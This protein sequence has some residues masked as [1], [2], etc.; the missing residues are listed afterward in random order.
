MLW[1]IRA[2]NG[3]VVM[4]VLCDIRV[5]GSYKTKRY[6]IVS[7]YF[8]CCDEIRVLYIQAKCSDDIG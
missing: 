2:S 6:F 1:G 8:A 5:K 3:P 7:Y 4:M